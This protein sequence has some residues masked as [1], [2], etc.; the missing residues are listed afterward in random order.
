MKTITCIIF[1]T[2]CAAAACCQKKVAGVYKSNFAINNMVTEKLTLLCDSAFVFVRQG[3]AKHFTARGTWQ[4]RDDHVFLHAD[5]ATSAAN[6]LLR[7]R[8]F[9]N[10]GRLLAFSPTDYKQYVTSTLKVKDTSTRVIDIPEPNMA[11][12]KNPGKFSLYYLQQ[13]SRSNCGNT[14][15]K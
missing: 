13:V 8:W 10:N 3:D 11:H 5:T 2:I 14:I 9:Y 12:Y 1:F 7:E 15:K 4:Y 6:P